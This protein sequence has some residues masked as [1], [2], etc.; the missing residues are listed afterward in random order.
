M[1]GRHEEATLYLEEKD[2]DDRS[3]QELAFHRT[4]LELRDAPRSDGLPIMEI[5]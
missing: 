3:Q 5:A 4:M 1:G 2:R